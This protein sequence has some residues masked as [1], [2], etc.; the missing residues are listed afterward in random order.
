MSSR[1]V[2]SLTAAVALAFVLLTTPAGAQPDR[3]A[4]VDPSTLR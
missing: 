4:N 3:W 1:I 2:F